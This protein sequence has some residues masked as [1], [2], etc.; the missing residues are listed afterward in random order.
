[1]SEPARPGRAILLGWP[2]VSLPALA[3]AA[4][5]G[6]LF[7]AAPAPQFPGDPGLV[8]FLV[9]LFAPVIETLIMA[10]VLEV[11]L[12]VVPPAWA[13]ALSALGWGIAHSLQAPTWGLVIWWP[14]LIFSMLYV[15]W[16]KRS[17]VAAMGI[18]A[19]VHALNNLIPGLL[20]LRSA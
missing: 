16:R 17:I 11:L 19:A 8:F 10:A 14:F 7:P 20:L 15:T 4:L 1:M 13:V 12:R 3:L 2:L 6:A 9:T 5:F 18:V